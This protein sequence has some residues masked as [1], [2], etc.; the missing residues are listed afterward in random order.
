MLT[1][2]GICTHSV[3]ARGVGNTYVKYLTPASA[4]WRLITAPARLGRFFDKEG[5][6]VRCKYCVRPCIILSLPQQL[7]CA[8]WLIV[9]GGCAEHDA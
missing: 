5:N 7:S 2:R 4:I 9:S 1:V 3:V 6:P 8:V